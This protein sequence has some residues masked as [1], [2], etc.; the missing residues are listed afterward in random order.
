[1][2]SKKVVNPVSEEQN[3][4]YKTPREI[5]NEQI[6]QAKQKLATQRFYFLVAMLVLIVIFAVGSIILLIRMPKLDENG[7]PV[8]DGGLFSVKTIT[9]EGN[10]AYPKEHVIQNSG[11]LIGQ[12]IFSVKAEDIEARLLKTYPQYSSVKVETLGMKEVKISVTQTPIIG[13]MYADGAWVLVGE[14]GNAVAKRDMTGDRPK[15]ILY[16]KGAKIPKGGVK[17]GAAAMDQETFAVVKTLSAAIKQYKLNDIAEIDV[18]NLSDIRMNW[19]DQIE[20][21]MGNSSNLAHEVEVV[22]DNI[23]RILD[24]RGEHV[25]GVLNVSS[26]SDEALKHQAVFTPSSV[27]KDPAQT[28]QVPEDTEQTQE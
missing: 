23:P 19:R 28:E 27:L 25:T 9:L 7:N 13:A 21:K 24:M 3:K 22:A 17:Y 16:I 2:I 18:G 10:T 8:A 20:V 26:Y 5:E 4:P 15:G 12:S 6:E 14:N 1:M 11:V